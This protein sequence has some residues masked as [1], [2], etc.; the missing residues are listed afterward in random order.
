MKL[1][2]A[3]YMALGIPILNIWPNL[4]RFLQSIRRFRDSKQWNPHVINAGKYLCA[5]VVTLAYFLDVRI[6]SASHSFKEWNW[7]RTV[8]IILSTISTIYRLGY[9][10]YVDW[11]LLR[12]NDVKYKFLRKEMTFKPMWYYCAIVVNF[13]LRFAWLI[14]LITLYFIGD[15]IKANGSI[16]WVDVIVGSFEVIRRFIWN[17]FR[18]D[19]EQ[20][21]NAGEYLPIRDIPLPFETSHFKPKRNLLLDFVK[22]IEKL[23]P[24]KL[25]HS[26]TTEE[27]EPVFFNEIVHPRE[28]ATK[29]ESQYFVIGKR[30]PVVTLDKSGDE[31]LSSIVKRLDQES[32]NDLLK[33][34]EDQNKKIEEIISTTKEKKE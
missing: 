23:W 26:L 2:C 3:N 9:D 28:R 18:L 17:I 33:I 22:N 24:F 29:K 13:I 1:A 10:Y 30:V 6:I 16:I 34:M 15:K 4:M 21:N 19:N 32:D 7:M 5:M 8:Y 31:E 27:D 12:I 25:L 14:L 11:G 20:L